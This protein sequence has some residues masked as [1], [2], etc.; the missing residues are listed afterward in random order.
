[1]AEKIT[2]S[3]SFK[4]DYQSL[5]QEIQKKA[6]KQIRF[7]FENP[8]HPS[9]K[10]HRLDDYYWEFYVDRFY[11]GVCTRKEGVLELLF[12]GTHKLIDRW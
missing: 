7:L 10:M 2:L 11:R 5:P 6:D 1:M 12:V 4:R 3:P 8:N 9:L